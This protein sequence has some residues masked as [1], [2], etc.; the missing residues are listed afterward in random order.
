MART[1]VRLT[2]TQ[3]LALP[4]AFGAVRG[5]TTL[6]LAVRWMCAAVAG[7]VMF[8]TLIV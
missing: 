3:P 6:P 8:L 2:F 1:N 5:T 7:S 4:L